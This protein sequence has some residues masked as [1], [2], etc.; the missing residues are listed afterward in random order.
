MIKILRNLF[1]KGLQ[2]RTACSTKKVNKEATKAKADIA[3]LL[4]SVEE[5]RRLIHSNVKV[6]DYAG[7]KVAT[8]EEAAHAIH[9]EYKN[10]LGI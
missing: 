5:I 3:K 2:S 1:I 8:S 6:I 9:Q 4:P 10:R 7:E